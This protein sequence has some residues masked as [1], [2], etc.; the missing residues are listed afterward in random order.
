[1]EKNKYHFLGYGGKRI[2]KIKF[3]LF[4]MSFFISFFTYSANWYVNDNSTA[5]N[6]YCT[7]VG[8]NANSGNSSA[9][10][11][12]TLG[13]ALALAAAGDSIFIDSG[14]YNGISHTTALSSITI[15]GAGTSLTIFDNNGA[16]SNTNLFFTITSLNF[17]LENLSI[18][19]YNNSVS[20]TA[21]GLSRYRDHNDITFN[22]SIFTLNNKTKTNYY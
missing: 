21:T 8:N 22:N 18:R 3:F 16:S 4:Y 14:T 9:T 17:T 6:V 1:M 12:L 15:K 11:K 2:N 13:A 7:A 20:S 5:G 10:P 19:E